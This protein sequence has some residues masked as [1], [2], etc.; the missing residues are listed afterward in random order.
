MAEL[1]AGCE[2][3]EVWVRRIPVDYASHGAQVERVRDEILD[4]L[5]P[6]RPGTAG[7]PMVSALTGAW[8]RGPETDAGYWY[9]NLRSPVEFDRAVATDILR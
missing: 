1:V 9:D 5:G 7:I 4:V 3:D 6:I 2:A 8:L